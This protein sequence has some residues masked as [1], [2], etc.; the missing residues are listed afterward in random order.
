MKT[1]LLST[2]IFLTTFQTL[3]AQL[4]VKGDAIYFYCSASTQNTQEGIER[5]EDPKDDNDP[6]FAHRPI[7]FEM[8]SKQK[9]IYI[10][11]IHCSFNPAE[12]SKTRPVDPAK[13]QMEI[14]K[15]PRTMLRF[16]N[17]FNPIT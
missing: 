9:N 12:L 4:R 14:V 7:T 3:N 10:L 1:L 11:F 16:I 6:L 13:D 17:T 2:I 5:Y 8:R 15:G